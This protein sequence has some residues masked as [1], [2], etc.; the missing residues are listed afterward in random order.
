MI[1]THLTQI[2]DLLEKKVDKIQWTRPI[3]G[4]TFDYN[5]ILEDY[6]FSV[7]RGDNGVARIVVRLIKPQSN[8]IIVYDYTG[9]EV[10]ALYNTIRISVNSE[11]GGILNN[12][13]SYLREL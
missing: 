1:D 3:G 13:I 11:A 5:C 10:E 7:T 6:S 12:L 4:F 9:E 8:T 2:I